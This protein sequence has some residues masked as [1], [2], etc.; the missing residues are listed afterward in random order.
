MRWKLN[1]LLKIQYLLQYKPRKEEALK[2]KKIYPHKKDNTVYN[3]R[4]KKKKNRLFIQMNVLKWVNK[5]TE[6]LGCNREHTN[7]AWNLKAI[8]GPTFTQFL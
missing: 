6:L 8:M 3:Q 2:K 7:K 1:K 5:Q 4:K